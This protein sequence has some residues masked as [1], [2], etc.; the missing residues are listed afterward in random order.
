MQKISIYL[1]PRASES[2]QDIGQL[3]EIVSQF[4]FRSELNFKK[5][6]N[7]DEL[8]QS[9]ENDIKEN[10]DAVVSVGGDGTANT[11]IQKLAGTDIGLLVVPCGTANDLAHEL[12]NNKNIS[13]VLQSIRNQTTKKIDLIKVNGRY[14]ATNGG[15]G[16]G[17]RVAQKINNL[18][19]SFPSFK[20][21]M[22]LSGSK[23]Y[24]LFVAQELMSLNFE[25]YQVRIT[26]EQKSGI[27]DAAALFI[28]NQSTVGGNFQLAPETKNS[29]GHFSV[30]L[31]TH[32]TRMSLINCIVKILLGDYPE[33]DPDL[34][35]FETDKILVENLG[36]EN[37][38]FFGDGEVLSHDQK[39]EIEVAKESLKVY[40]GPQNFGQSVPLPV[41]F[42]LT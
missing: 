15:F 32:K 33:N 41:N 34:I 17:G 25:R 5:P 42:G 11:I 20:K 9:L 2:G 26:S 1:N 19:A 36:G 28:N 6:S 30:V 13:Q 18:R 24:S 22:H 16:L 29:D 23:I 8:D 37:C 27:F 40:T 10:V 31:A 21:V 35:S 3:T 12:G 7:L 39:W 14:M 38:V 4:L